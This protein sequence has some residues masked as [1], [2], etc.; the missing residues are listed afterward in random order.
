MKREEKLQR[1]WKL[2]ATIACN[3]RANQ[4][5][6][7]LARKDNTSVFEKKINDN[8]SVSIDHDA[9]IAQQ[10]LAIRITLDLV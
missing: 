6:F 4:K 3:Y 1:N 10:N 9:T 8:K 5:A 7:G 2:H